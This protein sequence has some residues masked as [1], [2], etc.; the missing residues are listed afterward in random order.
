LFGSRAG[1]SYI[2]RQGLSDKIDRAHHIVW[3]T[4]GSFVPEDEHARFYE[5][6][7]RLAQHRNTGS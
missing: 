3:T 5:K 7:K 6:G 1:L 4:G 2:E